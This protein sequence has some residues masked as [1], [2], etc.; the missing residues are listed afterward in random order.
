MEQILVILR[1]EVEKVKQESDNDS[2]M[3]IVRSS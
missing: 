3:G 2:A 1:Q